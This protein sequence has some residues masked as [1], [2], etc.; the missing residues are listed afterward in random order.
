MSDNGQKPEQPPVINFPELTDSMED[1]RGQ[2]V[3]LFDSANT[4]DGKV[5]TILNENRK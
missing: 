4:S 1:N 5:Q 3:S 2:T